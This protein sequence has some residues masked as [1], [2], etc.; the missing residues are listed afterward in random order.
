MIKS[1]FMFFHQ[2]MEPPRTFTK[3]IRSLILGI[4]FI[5]SIAFLSTA[6][7]RLG[8][9]DRTETIEIGFRLAQAL[10][11]AET[12]KQATRFIENILASIDGISSISSIT[13]SG[14][15]T[16]TV[17]MKNR[18]F[19]ESVLANI[20]RQLEISREVLPKNLHFDQPVVFKNETR[21]ISL[22]LGPAFLQ[23]EKLREELHY[24]LSRQPQIRKLNWSG[25][26]EKTYSVTI[27]PQFLPILKHMKPPGNSSAV[28]VRV[29]EFNALP[30]IEKDKKIRIG[31][32]GYS[33]GQIIENIQSI[34]PI[35]Y[36]WNSLPVI[37]MDI[38]YLGN[39][40][41]HHFLSEWAKARQLADQ[42]KLRYESVEFRALQLPFLVDL[43]FLN[44]GLFISG[45]FQKSRK[46]YQKI[47]CFTILCAISSLMLKFLSEI[48]D[49]TLLLNALCL[50]GSLTVIYWGAI[51]S[52]L[53]VTLCISAVVV[54]TMLLNNFTLFLLLLIPVASILSALF[55]EENYPTTQKR[56]NRSANRKTAILSTFTLL[57]ISLVWII[58]RSIEDE[59]KEKSLVR[60]PGSVTDTM[61]IHL[62]FRNEQTESE[63]N[64]FVFSLESDL[65]RMVWAEGDLYSAVAQTGYVHIQIESKVI[66]HSIRQYLTRK[67]LRTS[68]VLWFISH[69]NFE[70]SNNRRPVFPKHHWKLYG[71]DLD[72]LSR[73]ADSVMFRLKRTPRV[74]DVRLADR[75][76]LP[77]RAEKPTL[78][79]L[80][81]D[82]HGIPLKTIGFPVFS[83]QKK[84]M[85]RPT[86]P[87]QWELLNRSYEIQKRKY[88]GFQLF[89]S[90]SDPGFAK[91]VKEDRQFI[92]QIAH[93]YSGTAKMNREFL[94]SAAHDISSLL[95]AGIYL[96]KESLEIAGLQN[97][98]T[99]LLKII[100]IFVICLLILHNSVINAVDKLLRFGLVYFVLQLFLLLFEMPLPEEWLIIP[101]ILM[102]QGILMHRSRQQPTWYSRSILLVTLLVYPFI[103]DVPLMISAGMYCFTG[104]N[105]LI[106][107]DL[108]LFSAESLPLLPWRGRQSS[109]RN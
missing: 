85:A 92:L 79:L 69:G 109:Q 5:S 12:E 84:I 94:R 75:S 58:Q 8:N 83:S 36:L 52:A 107:R 105:M 14:S 106:P 38:E 81:P 70:F 26:P 21:H 63:M 44:L 20:E 59:E 29:N 95:P 90:T 28:P 77:A 97:D 53:G 73:Y 78:F 46:Y 55:I 49:F 42:I 61:D 15:G 54:L 37:K 39:V 24:F 96:D 56:E 22:L 51:R 62:F 86:A 101:M 11:P 103:R 100:L 89:H 33:A 17:K 41:F 71:Y 47:M 98:S 27:Q 74:I 72:S 45:I 57:I 25:L 30:S 6:H 87:D 99:D 50:A 102:L 3:K 23:D 10:T 40:Q 13:N 88:R 31:P 91:I 93:D 82:V 34:Q 9:S 18:D 80:N 35:R 2:R 19:P 60:L 76:W 4:A 108:K 48:T 1:R 32:V 68:G 104:V 64:A 66:P 65:R 67:A 7:I 43:F 16:V